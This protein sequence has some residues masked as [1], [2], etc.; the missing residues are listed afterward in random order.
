MTYLLIQQ[1]SYLQKFYTEKQL[2]GKLKFHTGYNISVAFTF[3]WDIS[4]LR[5]TLYHKL[6][7]LSKSPA[8]HTFLIFIMPFSKILQTIFEALFQPFQHEMEGEWDVYREIRQRLYV[9]EDALH[10]FSNT[11]SNPFHLK[12]NK[13]SKLYISWF[14]EIFCKEKRNQKISQISGRQRATRRGW[15]WSLGAVI[16]YRRAYLKN[17]INRYAHPTGGRY[18]HSSNRTFWKILIISDPWILSSIPLNTSCYLRR[19]DVW[20]N[21]RRKWSYRT[22]KVSSGLGKCIRMIAIPWRFECGGINNL[23]LL[24]I[25]TNKKCAS[26]I[27]KGRSRGRISERSS[28]SLKWLNIPH[29]VILYFAILSR[30]DLLMT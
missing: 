16:W 25:D 5:L 19:K 29:F 10:F 3:L 9:A 12:I 14:F 17:L 2:Q 7:P 15:L 4:N 13:A 24:V 20:K 22:W 27:S 1:I 21:Y 18:I 30:F 6:T 26:K 28:K 23:V 11:T 8:S